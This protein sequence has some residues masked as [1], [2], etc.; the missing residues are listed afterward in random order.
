MMRAI[1]STLLVTT[2]FLFNFVEPI[3]LKDLMSRDSRSSSSRPAVRLNSILYRLRP[4]EKYAVYNNVVLAKI[5]HIQNAIFAEKDETGY[6]VYRNGGAEHFSPQA[7][8]MEMVCF[9]QLK[10]ENKWV[11]N[12]ANHLWQRHP[13]VRQRQAE[14]DAAAGR[15]PHRY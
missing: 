10:S 9:S 13:Y 15:V 12:V 5:N 7:W 11:C 14:R 4:N 6:V 2:P 1:I 8:M 3:T